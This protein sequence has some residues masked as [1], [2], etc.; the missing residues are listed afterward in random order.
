M[1]VTWFSRPPHHSVTDGKT[2]VGKVTSICHPDYAGDI[3]NCQRAEEC[4]LSQYKLIQNLFQW[5][6]YIPQRKVESI[7]YYFLFVIYALLLM[8]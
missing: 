7:Y 4:H 2:D 6:N 5:H 1:C 8:F 3:M